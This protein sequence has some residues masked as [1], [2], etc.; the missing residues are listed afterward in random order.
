MFQKENT[1]FPTI[2][3][4]APTALCQPP[5]QHHLGSTINRTVA[6]GYARALQQFATPSPSRGRLSPLQKPPQRGLV[7]QAIMAT[8]KSLPA[9]KAACNSFNFNREHMAQAD[10]CNL[11][12]SVVAKLVPEA[13]M[14]PTLATHSDPDAITIETLIAR[15]GPVS[16]SLLGMLPAHEGGS[17]VPRR[18]TVLVLHT[19]RDEYGCCFAVVVDGNPHARNAFKDAAEAMA[20]RIGKP[21]HE[22]GQPEMAAI[23]R[24]LAIRGE[25]M[26]TGEAI[27]DLINL[28]RAFEAHEA[29]ATSYRHFLEPLRKDLETN[30]LLD[31][32]INVAAMTSAQATYAR[33]VQIDGALPRETENALRAQIKLHPEYVKPFVPLQSPVASPDLFEQ[34]PAVRD[35]F[36]APSIAGRW[37][38]PATTEELKNVLRQ[39]P[40]LAAA[41]DAPENQERLAQLH[42]AISNTVLPPNHRGVSLQ[43]QFPV[44]Y[45]HVA[46]I[47]PINLWREAGP[48]DATGKLQMG[49]LHQEATPISGKL[50]EG[51][52]H[53]TFDTSAV[54][55]GGSAPIT[56]SIKFTGLPNVTTILPCKYPDKIVPLTRAMAGRDKAYPYGGTPLWH[57][58]K[59]RFPPD[60]PF[61]SCSNTSYEAHMIC[62][63]KYPAYQST[64]PELWRGKIGELYN[65][66][67]SKI[68]TCTVGNTEYRVEDMLHLPFDIVG[69]MW[70][71]VTIHSATLPSAVSC[72]F[73]PEHPAPTPLEVGENLRLPDSAF[74]QH[75]HAARF[76]N[77]VKDMRLA[78]G[79]TIRNGITYFAEALRQGI[80]Y[81]NDR[82]GKK[83]DFWLSG[84]VTPAQDGAARD[85]LTGDKGSVV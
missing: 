29:T 46:H 4:L 56:E 14:R 40:T 72:T 78:D 12:R 27:H 33:D 19:F 57:G 30:G 50:W 32:D 26:G 15:H 63:G 7:S 39:E 5:N 52:V 47:A 48:D 42:Q 44:T 23:E 64:L 58:D 68:Q 53:P 11:Q 69:A 37:T 3:R 31:D 67:Q 20:Q 75:F 54:Y 60:R 70:P 28:D 38:P 8:L 51:E 18:H 41:I 79:T 62:N 25:R 77:P 36:N 16:L 66:D 71:K 83:L 82:A 13:P 1:M 61:N 80:F 43:L 35:V 73:A 55:P 81:S 6:R 17:I 84:V 59:G 45:S 21:L 65:I 2:T 49:L 24:K 74:P 34:I 9:T 76:I 85:R 22:L 10:T